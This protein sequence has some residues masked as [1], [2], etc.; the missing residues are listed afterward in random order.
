MK[1]IFLALLIVANSCVFTV[2]QARDVQQIK[3]VSSWGGLGTPRKNELV[4]RNTGKDYRAN[5][6]RVEKKIVDYLIAAIDEPEIKKFELSNIG[7]TQEWLN[8]NATLGAEEYANHYISSGAQNQQEL[9]YSS[10]KNLQFVEKLLPSLLRGGWTDDYPQLQVEVIEK[11]G[12]KIVVSSDEQPLFMLPF[13]IRRTGAEFKTFNAN[14]SRA[15]GSLLPKKF[16]NKGRLTGTGLRGKLAEKVMQ[17]VKDDWEFLE[18]EN[19]A[20][21]ALATLKKTYTIKSADLNSYHG[22]D[23]GKEWVNGNS[24]EVNVYFVLT[25]E[26]FPKT[27]AVRLILPYRY[28][29]AENVELFIANIA[30][31]NTLAMSPPWLKKLI[32][33][34]EHTVWLRFVGDRSFSDKALQIFSADMK[35]LG[36][37]DLIP[38]VEKHK[39]EVA[40]ISVGGGLD[41][42]QSYWIVMPDGRVILWRYGYT[43]QLGWKETDFK[44]KECT[45]YTSG[46]VQCVGAVISPEGKI[47]SN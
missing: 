35:M 12:S 14:I 43:P 26:N 28:N 21:P 25:A 17:M 44:S 33:S 42:W 27:Y 13:E 47:I 24:G 46:R 38:E 2:A 10:F 41:Y 15:I 3:I 6:D 20:G 39:N 9:F 22:V 30:R 11:D 1:K 16:V 23:H 29:K 40:L 19:K 36:K 37:P 32:D 34:N 4:I 31:Y 8:A 5:G 45:S 18:V 7:I